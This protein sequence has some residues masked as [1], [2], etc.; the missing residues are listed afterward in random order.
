MKMI[1]LCLE[2]L[3]LRINIKLCNNKTKAYLLIKIKGLS[4]RLL[5]LLLLLL[6]LLLLLLKYVKWETLYW[7]KKVILLKIPT[8]PQYCERLTI[9]LKQR[10]PI[11][12]WADMKYTINK[13]V[14]QFLMCN[15]WAFCIY[16]TLLRNLADNQIDQTKNIVNLILRLFCHVMALSCKNVKNN[17]ITKKKL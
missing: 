14:K 6:S 9:S 11:H 16:Q 13:S 10:D 15:S 12:S 8:H 1:F 5:I 17:M 7:T 4:P 3:P 2:P